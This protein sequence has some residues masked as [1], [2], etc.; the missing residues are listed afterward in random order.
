MRQA[1]SNSAEHWRIRTLPLGCFP[2]PTTNKTL[3][4]L[5][6]VIDLGLGLGFGSG[7]GLTVGV[8]SFFK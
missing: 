3:K 2:L 4:K 6:N 8:A 5:A 1:S 7:L